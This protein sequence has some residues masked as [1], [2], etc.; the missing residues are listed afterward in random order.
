M[1]KK[2]EN[3]EVVNKPPKVMNTI[4]HNNVILP[5]QL[6]IIPEDYPPEEIIPS[7][8]YFEEE[9]NENNENKGENYEDSENNL[10]NNFSK[11]THCCI[12]M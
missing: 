6:T 4:D 12:V 5:K 9:N 10:N 1:I 3:D 8:Y 11:Q 7:E 2:K